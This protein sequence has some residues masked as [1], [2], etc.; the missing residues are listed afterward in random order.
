MS[1]KI[2]VVLRGLLVTQSVSA[3]LSRNVFVSNIMLVT[4]TLLVLTSPYFQT[5]NNPTI[6][7][8]LPLAIQPDMIFASEYSPNFIVTKTRPH[9]LRHDHHYPASPGALYIH[10]TSS[11]SKL[12]PLSP[13]GGPPIPPGPLMM[14]FIMLEL[15]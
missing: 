5:I 6:T 9:N 15:A 4:V 13:T 1:Y 14:E 12:P 7:H 10:S 2:T 11:A 3:P 8:Y